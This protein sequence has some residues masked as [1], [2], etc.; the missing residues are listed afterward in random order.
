MTTATDSWRTTQTRLGVL[1]A[2]AAEFE[3]NGYAAGSMANIVCRLREAGGPLGN[4]QATKGS[5]SYYFP[6][7]ADLAVAIAE[8]EARVTESVQAELHKLGLAGLDALIT[9]AHLYA[10]RLDRDVILRAA[11]R[12]HQERVVIEVEL[13]DPHPAAQA[14]IEAL[15][16]EARERGE[17]RDGLE[18][19]EAARHV[20][21]VFLG[22]YLTSAQT[23]GLPFRCALD[24]AWMSTLPGFGVAQPGRLLNRVLTACCRAG[25]W[26][27]SD[28]ATIVAR[29]R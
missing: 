15:L 22:T 17:V 12:L 28:A 27:V 1:R 24:A 9:G 25:G 18:I 7:K 21:A 14:R 8:E 2:A 19:P 3:A 10:D 11:F 6:T 29:G 23:A 16:V 26:D 4:A 20:Q 5:I 13:P